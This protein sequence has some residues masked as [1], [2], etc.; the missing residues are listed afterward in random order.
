A[1]VWGPLCFAIPMSLLASSPGVGAFLR[2]RRLLLIPTETRSEPL[3]ELSQNFKSLTES[4]HAGRMRDLILDP[5]LLEAHISQLAPI[6][7]SD[8]GASA[9]VGPGSLPGLSEAQ[10]DLCARALRLGPSGL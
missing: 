3:E 6:P 5:V 10:M 8:V 9:S 2:A 1:P 4:D 7:S